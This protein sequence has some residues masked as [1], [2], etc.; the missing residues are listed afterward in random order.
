MGLI[1][2]EKSTFAGALADPEGGFS[3]WK[4]LE[5]EAALVPTFKCEHAQQPRIQIN[6]K[7]KTPARIRGCYSRSARRGN[8][9]PLLLL[10]S[11]PPLHKID[12]LFRRATLVSPVEHSFPGV[13]RFT[14]KAEVVSLS[15][16]RERN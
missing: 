12:A 14:L 9:C 2:L 8:H 1:W 10:F 3:E 4:A 16:R 5:V 7:T 6:A 11:R 15:N 13:V